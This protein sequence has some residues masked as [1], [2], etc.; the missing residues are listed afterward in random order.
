MI[1]AMESRRNPCGAVWRDGLCYRHWHETIGAIEGA[2][3]P[4]RKPVQDRV[5]S[6][7]PGGVWIGQTAGRQERAI[8]A[9]VAAR[10]SRQT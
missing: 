1:C 5:L 7:H 10:K 6:S 8:A 2:G 9:S 4:S 3:L